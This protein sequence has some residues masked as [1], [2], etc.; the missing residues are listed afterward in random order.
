MIDFVN[1][2]IS[3]ISLI[4]NTILSILPSSPFQF[5]INNIDSSWLSSINYIFPVAT[6]V[7]H[8]QLYLSAVVV[9]YGIRIILRWTKVVSS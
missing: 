7:A 4:I 9:Y 5:V 2:I 3:T 6:V 1:L 8:L